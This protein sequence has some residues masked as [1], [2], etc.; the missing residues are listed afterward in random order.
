[1]SVLSFKLSNQG[2]GRERS[3][4]LG[5]L[6]ASSICIILI[7]HCTVRSVTQFDVQVASIIF[8]WGY[9]FICICQM[10]P[11]NDNSVPDPHW[12][13]GYWKLTPYTMKFL[14]YFV[15]IFKLLH[16]GRCKLDY[17]ALPDHSWKLNQEAFRNEERISGRCRG[18]EK[19]RESR[20]GVWI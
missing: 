18:K 17:P 19:M 16:V 13:Y 12:L 1:M 15:L 5:Y 11:V 14:Y 7:C 4:W 2:L 6:K 9:M 8:S 3:G 10:L 20:R